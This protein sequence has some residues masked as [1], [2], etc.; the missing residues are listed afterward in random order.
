[1]KARQNLRRRPL[2]PVTLLQNKP[3]P[4]KI[5]NLLEVAMSGLAEVAV[6]TGVQ[7][8]AAVLTGLVGLGVGILAGVPKLAMLTGPHLPLPLPRMPKSLRNRSGLI[9]VP[10]IAKRKNPTIR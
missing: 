4:Q 9:A 8:A 6:P 7:E 3:L 5:W 10:G 1:M 2:P